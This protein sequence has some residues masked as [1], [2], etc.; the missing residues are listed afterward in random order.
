MTPNPA[1]AT[2]RL[3]GQ[4]E[5]ALP[6]KF[7]FTRTTLDGLKVPAGK[8]RVWVYDSRVRNLCFSKSAT[9]TTAYYWSGKIGGRM[10][11]FKLADGSLE[12][13]QARQLAAEAESKRAHGVNPLDERKQ[14]RGEMTFRELFAWYLENHSKAKKRTWKD[15]EQKFNKFLQPIAGRKV[16]SI[17]RQDIATLHRKIGATVPG[18][19]N[20]VL[21]LI[22]SIFGQAAK[23]GVEVQNPAKGVDRFP[24]HDRARYLLP[25][26]LERFLAAVDNEPNPIW[27]DVFRVALF[28]GA[29]K[30]NILTMRWEEVDLP[31]NVWRIPGEKFK[32]GQPQTIHLPASVVEI[33][34][35]REG[36]KSEW[37]FPSDGPTGHASQPRHAW[38]RLLERAGL[39]ELWIHDLRR[40]LGSWMAAT[41]AS[42]SV[43]GKGLGHRTT[44]TTARYARLD[45]SPVKAGVDTAVAAMLAAAKPKP[46]PVG[47]GDTAK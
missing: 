32:N 1:A 29:R 7:P 45:L 11:R 16:S 35:A 27:K 9:G 15:D 47:S 42:L 3:A 26:E 43:I 44:S 41:G 46:E 39:K 33:L 25:D 8:D 24:E 18:S 30:N 19:A 2:L 22:S 36:R 31:A 13:E 17:T 34:R 40:S 12:V 21:A 23:L 5:K 28:T 4:T 37:V 6:R 14:A 10:S 38:D 20:R